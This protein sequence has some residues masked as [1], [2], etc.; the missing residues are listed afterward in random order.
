MTDWIKAE[1]GQLVEAITRAERSA[2]AAT[3]N[4]IDDRRPEKQAEVARL[5]EALETTEPY[6]RGHVVGIT[7]PP[8]AGKSAVSGT[9]SLGRACAKRAQRLRLSHATRFRTATADKLTRAPGSMSISGP[10]KARCQR[11]DSQEA[12]A[13]LRGPMNGHGYLPGNSAERLCDTFSTDGYSAAAGDRLRPA[14]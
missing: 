7:G 6:Q 13:I 3:L 14:A 9:R 5:F 4:L 11:G 2:V 10:G 12:S 1:S 8:G